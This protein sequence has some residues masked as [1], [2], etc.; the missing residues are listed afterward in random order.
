MILFLMFILSIFEMPYWYYQLLRIF[1]TIGLAYLAWLYYKAKLKYLPIIFSV[2]AI[3]F[4]PI[5]KI[6]FDR[7]AWQI[8]DI[9]FAIIVL[10]SLIFEKR[11]NNYLKNG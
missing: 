2:G 6:S 7:Y 4:N 9:S 8:L 1:G 11:I 10:V 3:L 5:I